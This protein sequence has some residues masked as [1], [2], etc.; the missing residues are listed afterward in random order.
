MIFEFISPDTLVIAG[1]I[2]VSVY[3]LSVFVYWTS[4]RREKFEAMRLQT[5]AARLDDYRAHLERQ[6]LELNM[7]FSSSERRWQELNHMVVAGQSSTDF[8]RGSDFSKGTALFFESHGLELDR[9]Q[10]REDLMFV[11]TPFHEDL[12]DEFDVVSDVGKN[13]GFQVLRGDEK[14]ESGDIFRKI[15]VLIASARIVVAN[16]SGR[17]P[18]VFYELGIAHALGKQVILLAQSESQVPFD[19]QSKPIVFYRN[20]RDLSERLA[21]MIGRAM[22]SSRTYR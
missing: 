14:L 22:V 5:E 11:L 3:L 15:L 1:A 10:Q 19:V 18:N 17:N 7:K 16:I 4:R 2:F 9:I 6:L 8:Y 13:F 20:N 21:S 12:K